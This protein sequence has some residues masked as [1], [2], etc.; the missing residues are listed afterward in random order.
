[1]TKH[2]LAN[3]IPDVWFGTFGIFPLEN[4]HMPFVSSS[5][6][7][8][9]MQVWRLELRKLS[10]ALRQLTGRHGKTRHKAW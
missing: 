10:R 6:W 3:G 5:S 2:F 4:W 7:L 8:E 1:M 9:G